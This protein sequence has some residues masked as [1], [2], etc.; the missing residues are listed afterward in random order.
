MK[1]QELIDLCEKAIVSEDKWGNRD[2]ASAQRQIGELW[3]LLK[4]GCDYKL[5][6]NSL[7]ITV[8][9]KGFM[10]FEML[11]IESEYFYLPTLKELEELNGEDWY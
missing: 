7:S 8:Y 11:D 9:Y 3:A 10:Y 4:A 5:D 1:R 6:H 2:S